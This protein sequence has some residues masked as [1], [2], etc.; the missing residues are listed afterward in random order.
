MMDKSIN[1]GRI[2]G[3]QISI[4]YSWFIV[5]GLVAWSLSSG[6]FPTFYPEKSTYHYWIMGI[7]S[8]ILLFISVLL[9]ELSHTLV[10]NR[11]GL[12]VHRIS[13][14]I[15]GGIAHLNEEPQNPYVEL[16]V[17]VAG[18]LCSVIL[19]G[20]FY[21]LEGMTEG[22]AK[23]IFGYVAFINL[24]LF[25]FN[26]IPGFPLDG[27]RILRAL[28]WMNSG[29]L[30]KSTEISTQFGKVFAFFMIFYGFF[31][32]VSGNIVGGAWLIFIGFFLYN[33]AEAGLRHTLIRR[34]L[35]GVKVSDIMTRDIV[36]VEEDLT[37]DRLVEDYFLKYRYVFFPVFKE[38]K[39]V[40]V[41]TL[42]DVRAVQKEMWPFK[43]IRDIMKPIKDD[44][45][46]S[47]KDEAFDV[48]EQMVMK[49]VGRFLVM[50][51]SELIGII[52][53]TDIMNLFKIKMDLGS[54]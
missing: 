12:R 8:S 27:G 4:H 2:F 43:L 47:S 49:N 6:Y 23:A 51:E 1:L 38:R 48:L 11:S 10:A 14:F 53:R 33:A 52:S 19:A 30:R 34:A 36:H 5:F 50:E 26:M 39:V 35:S 32:I 45:I 37:L 25:G 15:F 24:M 13:L 40:G 9:H 22:M 3:I 54:D 20:A 17:A 41:V 46:R 31:L 29:N 44:M 7:I 21:L 18:P 16:R 42:N 28:W